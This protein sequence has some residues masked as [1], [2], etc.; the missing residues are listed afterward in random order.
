MVCPIRQ[1]GVGFRRI[2]GTAPTALVREIEVGSSAE[3]IGRGTLGRNEKREA[4][5]EKR[6]HGMPCPYGREGTD[7]VVKISLRRA[8]NA[9]YTTLR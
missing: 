3:Q 7:F 6:G 5:D 4:G 1:H 2:V 8:T 9:T